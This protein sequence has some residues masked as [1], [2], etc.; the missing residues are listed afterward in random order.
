MMDC[1]QYALSDIQKNKPVG[2]LITLSDKKELF[3]FSQ[4]LKDLGKYLT[5]SLSFFGKCPEGGI[6]ADVGA[7]GIW[8]LTYA[9]KAASV[10][11]EK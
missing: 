8:T 6:I 9:E 3:H 4:I 1:G 2:M 5:N 10:L 7:E 11:P